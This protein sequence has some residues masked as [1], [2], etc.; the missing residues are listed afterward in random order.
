MRGSEVMPA[1]LRPVLGA[2]A[3]LICVGQPVLSA[4]GAGSERSCGRQLLGQGQHGAHDADVDAGGQKDP[5]ES[6]YPAG[7]W[8]DSVRMSVDCIDYIPA[9][10]RPDRR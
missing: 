10:G 1:N 6:I 4:A 2:Y 7:G 8:G 3:E 5:A 9:T